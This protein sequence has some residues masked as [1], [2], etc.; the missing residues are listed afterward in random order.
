MKHKWEFHEI[1][2]IRRNLNLPDRQIAKIL[3]EGKDYTI[4][5]RSVEQK[6]HR[7]GIKKREDEVVD[8]T[9]VYDW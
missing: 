7:L 9:H 2:F 4:T 8:I 6:R 5:K 3:S 1:E